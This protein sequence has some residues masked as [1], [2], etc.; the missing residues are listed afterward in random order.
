M[1]ITLL[2]ASA[3][4]CVT[5]YFALYSHDNNKFRLLPPGSKSEYPVGIK[6]KAE[7][8]GE[9]PPG[10]NALPGYKLSYVTDFKG[11]ALPPSWNVY[12]GVPGGVPGGQFAASHVVVA[13]G[14]LSLN[15]WRDPR[16][17]NRWVTGGLCQCEV[18][19]TYGAYFVRSRIT[20]PGPNE[21]ELLWPANNHWPPEIDFNET[22]GQ[23]D[24]TSS[25]LHYNAVNSIDQRHVGI[26][27]EKW[28]TWG[29]IWT[30][31]QIS[32]VVDGQ[33]W[34]II[35]TAYEIADVPMT[36]D[37]QQTARCVP[38]RPCSIHPASMQVDWV[39]EYT[40]K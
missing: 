38:G 3:A 20:G 36:L 28:H 7:P 39:A 1:V 29:L 33:V 25:T 10:A 16:Y 9:A 27:M 4:I 26:N 14:I 17:Q 22:G 6:D 11:T 35:T 34:G 5:I 23:V 31:K 21:V 15:T 12:T 19:R 32:Y 18:A 8:S 24:S 13:H 37:M 2:T 40:A 30:P